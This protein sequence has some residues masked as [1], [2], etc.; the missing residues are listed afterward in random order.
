[1]LDPANA[2]I[3][4]RN[5]ASGLRATFPQYQQ[6]FEK[7][8]NA[9]LAQ[10]DQWMARWEKI[11]APLHGVKYVEYH[12]EWVYFADRFG[13]K[14]VGSVELKPGIEPTPNHI[15]ELVQTIK[16]EKPQLL[17]CGAKSAHP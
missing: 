6:A 12:P 1:M 2:N 10:L 9:Y 15:V 3:A 16:Q 8:L 7:N 5:I 13:M 17:L 4:A 11:A 14:R